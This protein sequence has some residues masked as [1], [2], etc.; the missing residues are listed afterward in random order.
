VVHLDY[1]SL[2]E[3]FPKEI[4]PEWLGGNY[5]LMKM[6]LILISCPEYFLQIDTEEFYIKLFSS[7]V[8][9]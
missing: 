5:V 3:A 1:E 8:T 4:L 9:S 7:E 2:H 6:L